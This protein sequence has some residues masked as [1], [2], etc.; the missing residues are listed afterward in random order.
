MCLIIIKASSA[1]T[2]YLN[3]AHNCVYI[4]LGSHTESGLQTPVNGRFDLKANLILV[5]YVFKYKIVKKIGTEHVP[6]M[7]KYVLY[8]TIQYL[9]LP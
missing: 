1:N 5:G 6:N 3:K 4:P 9:M 2:S 7:N 8:A